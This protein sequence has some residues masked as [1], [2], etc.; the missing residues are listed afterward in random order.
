VFER[1]RIQLK[2]DFQDLS[3][4]ILEAVHAMDNLWYNQKLEEEYSE[5]FTDVCVALDKLQLVRK[6]FDDLTD[7]VMKNNVI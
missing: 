5:A 7:K 3:A 6:N 2:K 1:E 4:N